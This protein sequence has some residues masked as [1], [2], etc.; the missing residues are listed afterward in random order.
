MRVGTLSSRSGKKFKG[1]PSWEVARKLINELCDARIE[2]ARREYAEL[3]LTDEE[4][5]LSK[6]S[7]EI[8][9]TKAAGT[10]PEFH[11]FR[12]VEQQPQAK[13]NFQW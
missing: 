8:G 12:T 1:T 2:A 11:Y 10:W 6:L 9:V 4:I 3:L 7:T 5:D 13:G